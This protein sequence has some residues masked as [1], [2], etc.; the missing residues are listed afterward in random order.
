MMMARE[1]TPSSSPIDATTIAEVRAVLELAVREKNHSH[2]L[3][4]ALKK[5]A[6]EAR[7]K[8]L[9]PEQLLVLLKSIWGAIADVRY[10]PNLPEHE[11]MLRQLIG[12]CIDEY[13]TEP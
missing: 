10:A 6:A 4:V 11:T 8:S 5:L 9:R 12:I 3:R 2:S 7:A 13:F 1:F